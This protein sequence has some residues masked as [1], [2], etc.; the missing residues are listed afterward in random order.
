MPVGSRGATRTRISATAMAL[1]LAIPAW[2]I[3]AL[4]LHAFA[5]QPYF[6]YSDPPSALPPDD[7]ARWLM[8]GAAVFGS[9]LIAAPLGALIARRSARVGFLFTAALAWIV[10]LQALAALPE[11]QR[12]DIGLEFSCIDTCIA[13]LHTSQGFHPALILFAWA[14][15]LA[16]PASFA[17]LAVGV[18]FWA[19][20]VRAGAKF[21]VSE[22]RAVAR[23]LRAEIGSACRSM[24]GRRAPTLLL[25]GW[26]ALCVSLAF[27]AATASLGNAVLALV[28]LFL[29]PFGAAPIAVISLL[30][31][32]AGRPS[33]TPLSAPPWAAQPWAAPQPGSTPAAGPVPAPPWAV[34]QPAVPAPPSPDQPR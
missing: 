12:R 26:T 15:P 4:S 22:V 23:T 34:D 7:P 1:L 25:V 2:P 32:P 10:A 13:L 21:S 20:W 28:I 9:A 19:S 30:T 18:W 24:A 8:A 5:N 3:V 11:I 16:E 29:W 33:G 27:I 14:G 17:A 6:R 31:Q